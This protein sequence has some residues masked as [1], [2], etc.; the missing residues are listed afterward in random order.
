MWE[1]LLQ[2]QPTMLASLIKFPSI[3]PHQISWDY[4]GCI[5]S[6]LLLM[7][8][9]TNCIA[10]TFLFPVTGTSLTDT[11]TDNRGAVP[12]GIKWPLA[13]SRHGWEELVVFRNPRRKRGKIGTLCM[14]LGHFTEVGWIQGHSCSRCIES[15]EEMVTSMPL[16]YIW[17]WEPLVVL[18]MW[19]SSGWHSRTLSG[20]ALA[21]PV[22]EGLSFACFMGQRRSRR[23]SPENMRS[24]SFC[25]LAQKLGRNW[26]TSH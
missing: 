20:W 21:Q 15:W 17:L 2:H 4:Q 1:M 13:H 23:P 25:L 11:I 26:Q 8:H 10:P 18:K 16:L 9:F 12:S 19:A 6:K 7:N 5:N 22:L 14:A 24:K 3:P